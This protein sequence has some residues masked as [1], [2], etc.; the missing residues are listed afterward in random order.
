MF[1]GQCT[2]IL[3]IVCLL[4]TSKLPLAIIFLWDYVRYSV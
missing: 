1:S 2:K 4:E 3:L